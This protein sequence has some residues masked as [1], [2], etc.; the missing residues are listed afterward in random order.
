MARD[1]KGAVGGH[2]VR[3][4]AGLEDWFRLDLTTALCVLPSEGTSPASHLLPPTRLQA[5]P[6]AAVGWKV[7]TS[8]QVVL[9]P[10]T[11]AGLRLAEHPAAS[12]SLGSE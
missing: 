3:Y 4:R 7:A 8:S 12:Q 9:C 10:E 1:P 11:E 5:P 2:W 6:L